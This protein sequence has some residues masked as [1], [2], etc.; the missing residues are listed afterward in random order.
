MNDL[1]KKLDIKSIFDSIDKESKGRFKDSHLTKQ[2]IKK[3]KRHGSEFDKD[4]KFVYARGDIVIPVI[5][6][7]RSSKA[8]EFRSNQYDIALKKR[9][10]SIKINNG[11]F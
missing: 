4:V 5:I 3:Y 11:Y 1:A 9:I 7:S 10:I 2:Q 8:I 6:G